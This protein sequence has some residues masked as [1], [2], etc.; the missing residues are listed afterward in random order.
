[1]LP[2]VSIDAVAGTY[3]AVVC[4]GGLDSPSFCLDGGVDGADGVL[5]GL[6]GLRLR[7]QF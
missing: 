7:G 6:R 2:T 3:V 5:R 1:M 4:G